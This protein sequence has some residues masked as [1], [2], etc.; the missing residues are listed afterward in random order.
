MRRYA[1]V[2]LPALILGLNPA[3]AAQK[4]LNVPAEYK[5][6]QA[7]IDVARDSDTVLV[8]PG[9]YSEN[10]DFKGKAIVVRSTSGRAM[11]SINASKNGSVVT[12][13]SGEGPASVIQGFRIAGGTGT[14]TT[15]GDLFGGGIY[16]EGASPR[17]IGN[18]IESNTIST[19]PAGWLGGA[20]IFCRDGSPEILDNVIAGNRLWTS[21]TALARGGGILCL[22]SSARIAG[23]KITANFAAYGDGGGIYCDRGGAPTITRNVFRGN[24]AGS[25]L[26]SDSAGGAIYSGNASPTI[27]ENWIAENA[28]FGSN[29]R[30]GGI[31]CGRVTIVSN[32]FSANRAEHVAGSQGGAIYCTD[33][34]ITNNT[35]RHN[36]ATT[37]GALNCGGG[38]TVT[39]SIFW[40]QYSTNAIHDRNASAT[41]QYCCIYGGW[42]GV[43]N[44]ATDPQFVAASDHHLRHDSSCRNKG[45]NR[46]PGLN[47]TDFEGDPRVADGTV[48]IGADE[49]FPRLYHIGDARAGGPYEPHLIGN[50]AA[51]AFWAVSMSI[52]DPPLSVPGLNGQL[53][54][55]PSRLA[56]I[57]LGAIPTTGHLSFSLVIPTTFPVMKVPTQ[58]LM[59]THFSNL[60]E[61]NVYR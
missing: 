45:S 20:G 52:L 15:T 22:N 44:I 40:L 27:S 9:T 56:I 32:I 13:K 41:F 7:A 39:N 16:C 14:A 36:G 54:L 29:P 1:V 26:G 4:T 31:F 30:G 28:A 33:A 23:N 47:Q 2:L 37:G 3:L 58:A 59:G 51:F 38:T 12:F 24:T 57:P 5:T 43:G 18:L 19:V 25:F 34:T 17:I 50:P 6:I 35:F 21:T 8:A 49:F 11:T 60:D 46:A 42:P 61:V 10:I 48:D 55:E 53:C